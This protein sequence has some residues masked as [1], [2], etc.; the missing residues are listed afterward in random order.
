MTKKFRG[1]ILTIFLLL[2]IFYVAVEALFPLLRYIGLHQDNKVK[3][4]HFGNW[5]LVIFYSLLFGFFILAFA[6]PQQKKNWR[7]LGL[8]QGFI[9]ALYF[10]MYGFPLTIYILSSYL[11]YNLSLKH[12]SGHLVAKLLTLFMNNELAEVIVML[13]SGILLIAA[14]LLIYFGWR[15]IYY[16]KETLVTDGIY[17]FLRHPQYLG[18]VLITVALL[19]HWPTVITLV[20]WPILVFIYLKLARQEDRYLIEQYPEAFAKYKAQTNAFIPWLR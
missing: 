19:I 15:K 12:S 7:S 10:E 16:S 3:I 20:M 8:L 17:K 4:A 5:S 2:F 6:F 13:I 11:G 18:F 14:A 1:Y 9:V